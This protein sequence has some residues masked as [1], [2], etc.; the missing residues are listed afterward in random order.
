MRGFEARA[1]HNDAEVL[2]MLESKLLLVT[3]DHEIIT[4][5][6]RALSVYRSAVEV[7]PDPLHALMRISQARPDLVLVDAAIDDCGGASLRERMNADGRF[8]SI[9]VIELVPDCVEPAVGRYRALFGADSVVLHPSIGASSARVFRGPRGPPAGCPTAGPN[10]RRGESCA[11]RA[12]G[13]E[14]LECTRARKTK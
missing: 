2:E 11:L 8:A 13:D 9:P 6:R 4:W 10:R 7:S 1:T 14:R 3:D 5:V 12:A